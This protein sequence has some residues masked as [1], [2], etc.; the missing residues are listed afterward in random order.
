MRRCGKSV[1]LFQLYKEY[2]LS[3][4]VKESNIITLA[5]DT[6]EYAKYRNPI[7]L[8]KYIREKII[9]DKKRYYVFIDEIQFVSEIRKP[10]VDDLEAK[11]T[12][13]DVIMGKQG[14]RI[15]DS[16]SGSYR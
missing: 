9:D 10:Y 12:F 13:I 6:L 5:L 15:R 3:E 2:L 8:D 7:E 16:C 14:S 1:L 4:G 11:I